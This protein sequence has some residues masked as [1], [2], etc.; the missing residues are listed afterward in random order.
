MEIRIF[1]RF[2]TTNVGWNL[3][4]TRKFL[5]LGYSCCVLLRVKTLGL[6]VGVSPARIS[7]IKVGESLLV[8]GVDWRGSL[9]R[10]G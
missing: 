1:P 4:L 5:T 3:E 9:D 6:L 2:G 10:I 7:F 8:G